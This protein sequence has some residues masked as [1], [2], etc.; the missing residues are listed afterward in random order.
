MADNLLVVHGGGPTAVINASLYGVIRE[1]K[2]NPSIGKVLGAIGGTGAIFTE[3]FLD[4]TAFSD[5]KLKLL[6]HTPASAIGSSRYP[7]YEEDYAKMPE[8]FKKHHIGY[9][10]L[11]GGNGTMD[12]CEHIYEVCR[13]HGIGVAGIAK[14]FG[15]N[16]GKKI[17]VAAVKKIPGEVIAKINQKIGFR[18]LTKFG[19]KGL[20]NLGKMIPLVGAVIN[21]GFDFVET[22][23]IADRAY[24]LFF[25]G[26]TDDCDDVFIISED[27]ITEI[28][29][30]NEPTVEESKP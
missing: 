2:K 12:A 25:L 18:L 1:A 30:D 22:K 14:N 27:G 6:L 10:L 21:G 4:L 29:T 13:D 23:V 24:N 3:Q 11:N 16:F 8:I 17:A 5:E 20:V 15:I 28:D 19:E 9:V 7:L 26:N